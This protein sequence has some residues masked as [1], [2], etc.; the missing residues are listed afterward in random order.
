M[1]D[2][3]SPPPATTADGELA[4]AKL[5]AIS[6]D[7]RGCAILTADG[8]VLAASGDP[9]AWDG[10]ASAMIQA[11][12]RA[13]DAP[14]TQIHVATEDGEVFAVRERD[15]AIVAAAE[16]FALAS[17][18]VCDLRATLRELRRVAAG[19]PAEPAQPVGEAA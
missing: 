6:S 11:A 12:D 3:L 17:L 1:P 13:I 8:S 7:L 14:A 5:S 16:R 10:V 2:R 15:Y 18:F 4:I 19:A 9:A